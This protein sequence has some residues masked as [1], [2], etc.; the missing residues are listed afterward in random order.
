MQLAFKGLNYSLI[1]LKAAKS[2]LIVY[3]DNK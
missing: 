2:L 1:P 3:N